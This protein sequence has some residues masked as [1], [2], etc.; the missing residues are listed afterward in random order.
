MLGIED[1]I[2]IEKERDHEARFKFNTP[3]R[4]IQLRMGTAADVMPALDWSH[5]AIVWLDYDDPLSPSILDD[6][7]MVATRA[8]TGTAFAVSVQVEKIF[9][10]RGIH[11]EALEIT[12]RDQFHD[13]F[14]SART[15]PDLVQSN[16]RGWN[17][18]RTSR[19]ILKLEIEN[20]LRH[21]N[22]GRTVGQ[23]LQFRQIA[24]I[25]Y[26][27]GAKMTTIVGVFVDQGQNALFEAGGFR[28]LPFYRDAQ[29]ALRIKVPLLTPNEMRHLDRS[30]PCPEGEDIELGPIPESDGKNYAKLY[31]YL[32]NFA[33]FEP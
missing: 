30:L 6:V 17:I 8:I 7:R 32:P 4:G 23:K 22:A 14:G 26:A 31:R 10:K 18:A 16:L 11:D 27:D 2:S 33:S 15:P 9:D 28:D 19:D 20:G 21:V 29:D 12:N 5:R 1:I 3:Y 13:L 24:A 25:E